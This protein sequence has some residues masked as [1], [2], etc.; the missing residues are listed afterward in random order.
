MFIS[1]IRLNIIIF[2]ELI[3]K[4]KKFGHFNLMIQSEFE[5]SDIYVY[6]TM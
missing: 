5:F 2:F 6:N 4:Y 3:S 1:N